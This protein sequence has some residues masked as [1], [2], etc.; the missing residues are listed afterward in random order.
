MCKT[1]CGLGQGVCD[2]SECKIVNEQLVEMQLLLQKQEE[3]IRTLKQ[4]PALS[5]VMG[6]L[7]EN[8]RAWEE[9]QSK[10]MDEEKSLTDDTDF[11]DERLIL[12]E[13]INLSEQI[14]NDLEEIINKNSP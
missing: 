7:Q 11:D 2:P 8:K 5:I 14:I 9:R 4:T 13:N 1:V 3:I 10:W 12:I 6:C